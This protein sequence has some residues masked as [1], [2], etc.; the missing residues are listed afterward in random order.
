MEVLYHSNKK[1]MRWKYMMAFVLTRF[2]W[3]LKLLLK[4]LLT[5]GIS[6]FYA[7]IGLLGCNDTPLPFFV[8][9][10][11]AVLIFAAALIKCEQGSDPQAQTV[12]CLKDKFI[13]AVVFLLTG[14]VIFVSAFVLFQ[15][16]DYIYGVQGRYF[17]PMMPLLFLL[18]DNKKIVWTKFHIFLIVCLIILIPFSFTTI[19]NRFYTGVWY[20]DNFKKQI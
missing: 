1:P 8:L 4:T 19:I 3:F 2:G 10:F 11:Y 5:Y 12:L 17:I 18:F 6:Y 9:N 7:F 20:A 14:L 15:F 13:F 16:H